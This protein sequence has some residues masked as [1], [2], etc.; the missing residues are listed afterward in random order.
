MAAF[1][2]QVRNKPGLSPDE[3]MIVVAPGVLREL[4]IPRPASH[5]SPL[6]WMGQQIDVEENRD[7]RHPLVDWMVAKPNRLFPNSIANRYWKHFL[8]RGLVEPED[9][10]RITNP[11]SN[12]LLLDTLA[13]Q[14]IDS[15]YDLKALIRNICNSQTYQLDTEPNGSNLRDRKNY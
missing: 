6:D 13:N 12:P 5:S 3:A 9:D 15:R 2:S 8:G 1:F 11:P 7:P 4:R 10:M 14:L